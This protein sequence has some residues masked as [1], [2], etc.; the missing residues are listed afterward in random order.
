MTDFDTSTT[1]CSLVQ[2]LLKKIQKKFLK[3]MMKTLNFFHGI[4][5]LILMTIIPRKKLMKETNNKLKERERKVHEMKLR[6]STSRYFFMYV[7][8]NFIQCK[9]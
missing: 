5:I 6:I 7:Q 3:L 8:F 2:V 9:K 4:L 1:V